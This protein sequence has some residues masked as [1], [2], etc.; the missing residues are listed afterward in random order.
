MVKKHAESSSKEHD[1][2][3]KKASTVETIDEPPFKKR[4]VVHYQENES[5]EDLVDCRTINDNDVAP[6]YPSSFNNRTAEVEQSRVTPS[7]NRK[8]KSPDLQQGQTFDSD[9]TVIPSTIRKSTKKPAMKDTY[10]ST[11]VRSMEIEEEDRDGYGGEKTR[12]R[13]ERYEETKSSYRNAN[14]GKQL[15]FVSSSL[16]LPAI[17]ESAENVN[18]SGDESSG[19]EDREIV[20]SMFYVAL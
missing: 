7:I 18:S 10:F 16:R 3:I 2:S 5:G 19:E 14:S 11:S 17:G 6:R 15:P 8:R 9:V 20:M 12:R 13:I 4:P 1:I